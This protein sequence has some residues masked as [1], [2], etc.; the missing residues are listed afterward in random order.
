MFPWLLGYMEPF[1]ASVLTIIVGPGLVGLLAG[2]AQWYAV[3]AVWDWLGRRL[4]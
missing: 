1:P 4:V 2:G 3:G